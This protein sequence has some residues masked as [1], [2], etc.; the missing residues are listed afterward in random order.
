MV[1]TP[2]EIRLQ[3]VEHACTTY[4]S[5]AAHESFII[6][7]NVAKA[8]PQISNCRSRI[9]SIFDITVEIV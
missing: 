9:F 1:I 4:G 5:H 8:R 2:L 3:P 7:E 6:V